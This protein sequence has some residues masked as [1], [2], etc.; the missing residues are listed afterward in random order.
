MLQSVVPDP[1]FLGR[2]IRKSKGSLGMM[3]NTAEEPSTQTW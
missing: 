3:L 1:L 2:R